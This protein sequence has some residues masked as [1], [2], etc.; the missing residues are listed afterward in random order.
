LR[1]AV[2]ERS[3]QEMLRSDPTWQNH[4]TVIGWLERPL[5]AISVDPGNA[6]VQ[7]TTIVRMRLPI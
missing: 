1:R 2:V 6:G 5:M 3:M 7:R 4:V